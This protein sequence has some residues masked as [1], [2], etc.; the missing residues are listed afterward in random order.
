[1]QNAGREDY[2]SMANAV[3]VDHGNGSFQGDA[4][5][6]RL[7]TPV[8]YEVSSGE[9][10]TTDYVIRYVIDDADAAIQKATGEGE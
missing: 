4:R 2:G 7:D 3:Q 10:F 6:Y 1:M 8:E 9:R 5:L